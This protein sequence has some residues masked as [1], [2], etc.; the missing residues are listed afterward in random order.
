VYNYDPFIHYLL[1]SSGCVNREC[2][3]TLLDRIDYNV[4]QTATRVEKGLTQLQKAEKYQRKNRKMLVI[5]ILFV[6]VVILLIILI[7]VKS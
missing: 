1:I 6:M 2:Q 7:A 5:S 3:G 4:E